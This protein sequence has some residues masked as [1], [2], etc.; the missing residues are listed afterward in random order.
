MALY[1]H[2][3]WCAVKQSYNQSS[4]NLSLKRPLMDCATSQVG[5]RR[6]IISW[7]QPWIW[8][9]Y[10]TFCHSLGLI[11]LRNEMAHYIWH[12]SQ[13]IAA[14][15]LEEG[16]ASSQSTSLSFGRLPDPINNERNCSTCPQLLNCTLYQRLV[17]APS[18]RGSVFTLYWSS[19]LHSCDHTCVPSNI[20]VIFLP[21]SQLIKFSVPSSAI[22]C[23]FR[24]CS[25]LVC[26]CHLCPMMIE[27]QRRYPFRCRLKIKSFSFYLL[28]AFDIAGPLKCSS[29][30]LGMPCC[31]WCRHRC[32]TWAIPI[33]ST[34]LSGVGC[35]IL[36]SLPSRSDQTS[37]Q[38]VCG[39]RRAF[40]GESFRFKWTCTLKCEYR[41]IF[42][43]LDD[44]IMSWSVD[45]ESVFFF[46]E[47]RG[48]CLAGLVL[49]SKEFREIGPECFR[50][51]FQRSAGCRRW[52][53][54]QHPPYS[55]VVAC[56]IWIV[57]V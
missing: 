45:E 53:H 7:D 23:C 1:S 2:L 26:T 33:L 38:P 10:F 41:G 39:C 15:G 27:I 51:V 44:L 12:S 34:S 52:G 30:H 13:R 48:E 3:C 22:R 8:Q 19:L 4:R 28:S 50:H 36:S 37:A 16:G 21:V 46:R 40:S 57:W 42:W 24:L 11:Q 9:R 31:T 54:V 49:M 25:I 17:T 55:L 32:H 35:S 47:E 29:R 20:R 18:I 43:I 56:V 14:D 6:R 5:V